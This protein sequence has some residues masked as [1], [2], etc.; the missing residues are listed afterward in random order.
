MPGVVA[1]GL[2]CLAIY[3][4][5]LLIFGLWMVSFFIKERWP[6]AK[7]TTSVERLRYLLR[8]WSDYYKEES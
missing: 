8:H 2:S 3:G 1:T 6:Y 5:L 4:G 7:G